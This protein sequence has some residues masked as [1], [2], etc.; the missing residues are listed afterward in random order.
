MAKKVVWN[1]VVLDYR[2][3]VHSTEKAYL[4][5]FVDGE[6]DGYTFWVSKKLI[7]DNDNKHNKD[8]KDGQVALSFTNEFNFNIFKTVERANGMFEKDI[9][10]TISA[11]KMK[12]LLS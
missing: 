12:Q 5:G 3:L 1:K 2:Q 6:F 11:S 4:I 8:L 7:T 9:V 10:I